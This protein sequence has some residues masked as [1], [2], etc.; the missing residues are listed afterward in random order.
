MEV[1]TRPNEGKRHTYVFT[2]YCLDTIETSRKFTAELTF[3]NPTKL[4]SQVNK[5]RTNPYPCLEKDLNR[6][7]LACFSTLQIAPFLSN[8]SRGSIEVYVKIEQIV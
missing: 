8:E 6:D 3:N 1:E 7:N 2:V 5:F 4:S